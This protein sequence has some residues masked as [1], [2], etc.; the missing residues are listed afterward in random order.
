MSCT[1]AANLLVLWPTNRCNLQCRYCYACTGAPPQDMSPDVARTA[2][3]AMG[4]APFSLQIAGGEPLLVPDRVEAIADYVRQKHPHTLISLQT[5]ATRVT[6]SVAGMLRKHRIGVGVS[7]D[8]PPE[9]NEWQ[10]GGT[11]QAIQGIQ[12][13]GRAG[14][15]VGLNAVITAQSADALAKWAALAYTLGNVAGLALDLLRH[16]GRAMREDACRPASPDQI[17]AGLVALQARVRTLERLSGRTVVIR[18]VAE[19]RARLR[20]AAHAQ[21]CYAACGRSFVVVPDGQ[22]YAC[23]SLVGDARYR[24]GH[25]SEPDSFRAVCLP[26]AE[27]R[28]CTAC[29]YRQACTKGCPSRML[30]D[31]QGGFA[32]ECALRHTAFALAE[33][34]ASIQ[35]GEDDH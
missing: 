15:R 31:A 34:A 35:K 18:E 20:T 11:A 27:S 4:S 17:A 1:A 12:T 26:Q 14:I 22:V 29:R 19:A 32:A 3:D 16:F 23:G 6:P 33:G 5:N 10:R 21:H 30:G 2:I 9:V 24:V 13:L 25:V 7:L 28:R 8:G